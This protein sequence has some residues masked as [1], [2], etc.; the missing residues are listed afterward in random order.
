MATH[1]YGCQNCFEVAKSAALQI[2]PFVGRPFAV[3]IIM[4]GYG[5]IAMDFFDG[6]EIKF[7]MTFNNVI[8]TVIV[9][10]TA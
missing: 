4:H 6:M 5:D 1:Q 7:L 9:G 2:N 3:T 10:K 8:F